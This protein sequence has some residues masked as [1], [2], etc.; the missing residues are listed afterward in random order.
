M[1]EEIWLLEFCW[2]WWFGYWNFLAISLAVAILKYDIY[3]ILWFL[4]M[5]FFICN[6]PNRDF[7]IC[8]GFYLWFFLI[9]SGF[10]IQNLFDIAFLNYNFF[11]YRVLEHDNPKPCYFIKSFCNYAILLNFL[12]FY[13]NSIRSPLLF[14]FYYCNTRMI[15]ATSYT[16]LFSWSSFQ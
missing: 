5:T 6:V 13:A 3:L 15:H 14:C 7:F 4:I 2:L 12:I 16:I 1:H 11:I 9:Y 10:E 8:R